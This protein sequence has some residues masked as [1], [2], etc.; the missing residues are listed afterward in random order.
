MRY[1]IEADYYSSGIWLDNGSNTNPPNYLSNA[2][3]CFLECWHSRWEC[4]Y[5]NAH[6][7]SFIPPSDAVLNHWKYQ[8]RTLAGMMNKE[9]KQKGKD[10]KFQFRY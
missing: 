4:M 2:A 7:D 10:D 6:D 9:A 8:G 3:K 5:A 1:T